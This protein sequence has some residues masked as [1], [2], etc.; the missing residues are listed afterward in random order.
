M[1]LLELAAIVSRTFQ[2]DSD[3]NSNKKIQKVKNS[4]SRDVVTGLDLLLHNLSKNYAKKYFSDHSFIS[5]ESFD[6]NNLKVSFSRGDMFIVDPLDGS[7]NYSIHSNDYGYMGC[8]ITDKKISN[9]L[10]VIPKKSQYV[11]YDDEQV[12]LSHKLKQL[13][14]SHISNSY[15]AYNPMLS[16]EERNVRSMLLNF[17]DDETTGLVRYGSACVGLYN[18][19][20]NHHSM[21]IG[22]KI[23]VWD[24]IAFFPILQNYGVLI[25]YYLHEEN[26][27]LIASRNVDLVNGAK[28]I[29]ESM[30][31]KKMSYYSV[32]NTLNWEL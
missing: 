23:R 20:T 11:I 14:L 8:V 22:Q 10:I 9:S 7:H 4:N 31:N 6:K 2:E 19:L 27:Y 15:Y 26:M 13:S 1:K 16:D 28:A 17:I 21:F 18:L 30:L 24:A 3:L 29:F 5:E 12:Y 32:K 25:S